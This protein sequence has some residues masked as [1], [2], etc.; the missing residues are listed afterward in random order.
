EIADLPDGE[1]T[2]D[3]PYLELKVL[4]TEP[5]PSMR[6]QIEEALKGK[7]VRLTSA[8]PYKVKHDKDT[9]T[10]TYEEL[11]TINPME[12]AEDVFLN[13]YG[14]GMPDTMKSLLQ[15]VIEEASR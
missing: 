3:S 1:I 9:R 15:N 14:N 10:V 5:E 2:S 13:K 4:I 8:V 11:K 7:S 6:N 12:M